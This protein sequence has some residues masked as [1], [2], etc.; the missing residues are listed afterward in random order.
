MFGGKLIEVLSNEIGK[1]GT[2]YEIEKGTDNESNTAIFETNTQNMNNI[3]STVQQYLSMVAFQEFL[4][5]V[6][7]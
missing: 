2:E 6:L 7:F 4:I 1:K 3:T 5:K